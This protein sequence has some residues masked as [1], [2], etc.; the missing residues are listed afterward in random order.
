MRLIF[1]FIINHKL[2]FISLLYQDLIKQIHPLILIN[3]FIEKEIYGK[4]FQ[5]LIHQ[6][7]LLNLCFIIKLQKF[8]FLM[9]LLILMEILLCNFP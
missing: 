8:L 5:G 9:F 4:D 1:L 3:L 2:Q 7:I 6:V